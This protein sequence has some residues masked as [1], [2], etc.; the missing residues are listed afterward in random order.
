ML[1]LEAGIKQLAG[2]RS[3]E[4]KICGIPEMK[5]ITAGGLLQSWD[6]TR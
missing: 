4:G 3:L 6:E 2:T 1:E 5:E